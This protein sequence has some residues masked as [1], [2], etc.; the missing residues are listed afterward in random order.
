MWEVSSDWI[1]CFSKT[2][3]MI[4]CLV[5]SGCTF[6]AN[7]SE[8]QNDDSTVV[9]EHLGDDPTEEIQR[10][11]QELE[12]EKKVNEQSG[13]LMIDFGSQETA[14]P[15]TPECEADLGDGDDKRDFDSPHGVDPRNPVTLSH[16]SARRTGSRRK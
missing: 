8:N 12:V 13:E 11:E 2:F 1:D 15:Q 16:R 10:T 5:L 4:G 7:V 6:S 3:M 14:T 9:P